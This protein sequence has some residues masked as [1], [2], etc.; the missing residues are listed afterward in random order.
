MNPNWE[1]CERCKA[2]HEAHS[3]RS[4]SWDQIIDYGVHLALDHTVIVNEQIEL[5][6]L[7]SQV[8]AEGG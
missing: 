6:P 3:V 4:I 5:L 8:N 2:L 1:A 7:E